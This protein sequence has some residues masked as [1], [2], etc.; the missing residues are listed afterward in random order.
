MSE[1]AAFRRHALLPKSKHAPKRG[2]VPSLPQDQLSWL[3]GRLGPAQRA[4]LRQIAQNGDFLTVDGRTYLLAPVTA[5]TIDALAAFETEGEDRECDLEDEP[6]T[7]EEGAA[8]P[9]SHNGHLSGG[10]GT[11]DDEDTHDAE[12]DPGVLPFPSEKRPREVIVAEKRQR[13]RAEP[14]HDRDE[15]RRVSRMVE[16]IDMQTGETR[17][18]EFVPVR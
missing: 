6:G 10:L 3:A 1:T 16:V 13:R 11:E 15:Q 2:F 14:W 12:L 18:A 7:D 9:T 5:E 8:W 4:P 17:R